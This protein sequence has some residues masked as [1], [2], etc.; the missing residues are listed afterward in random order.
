MSTVYVPTAL[1]ALTGNTGS[2]EPSGGNVGD[3]IDTI[4]AR[5]PGFRAALVRDGA[6]APHLAVS[7]DGVISPDGLA[8]PVEEESEIHFVPALGG[9]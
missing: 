6:L 9:G 7:V 5:F 2:L 3:L 1:L 4:D 8:E